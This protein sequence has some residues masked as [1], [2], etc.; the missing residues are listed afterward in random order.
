MHIYK[1]E[2]T[3]EY[4]QNRI[5]NFSNETN[6]ISSEVSFILDNYD[7]LGETEIQKDSLEFLKKVSDVEDLKIINVLSTC[8][9]VDFLIKHYQLSLI[10]EEKELLFEILGSLLKNSKDLKT[11]YIL[12]FILSQLSLIKSN[13]DVNYNLLYHILYAIYQFFSKKYLEILKKDNF[14]Q[15]LFELFNLTPEIDMLLL[16][17]SLKCA[18]LFEFNDEI[19]QFILHSIEFYNNETTSIIS[20]IIYSAFK[21]DS[22]ILENDLVKDTIVE[23]FTNSNNFISQKYALKLFSRLQE[24][25][26]YFLNYSPSIVETIFSIFERTNHQES[27][28]LLKYSISVVYRTIQISLPLAESLFFN[29]TN[30]LTLFFSEI[31]L[32]ESYELRNLGIKVFSQIMRIL[33]RKIFPFLIQPELTKILYDILVTVIDID[34]NEDSLI[35]FLTSI[36]KFLD[37]LSNEQTLLFN[38]IL[39]FQSEEV[40]EKISILSE[41]ENEELADTFLMISEKLTNLEENLSI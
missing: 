7:Q 37:I 8:P 10:E 9:L 32:E 14:I 25:N 26:I 19:T 41:S 33:P 21:R 28:P 1:E 40:K 12:D 15:Q 6:D 35:L 31:I 17:Y 30:D 3:K 11:D 4:F 27:H 23:C 16:Q 22:N 36:D 20:L 5:K 39:I 38:F 18:E 2:L 29:E 13:E 34:E 24:D